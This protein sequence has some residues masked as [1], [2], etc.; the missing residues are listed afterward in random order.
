M[1]PTNINQIIKRNY[2][3]TMIYMDDA[4]S[5]RTCYYSCDEITNQL[6][7]DDEDVGVDDFFKE[8]MKV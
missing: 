8:K 7:I 3:N 1:H 5:L 4:G 6:D 2:F